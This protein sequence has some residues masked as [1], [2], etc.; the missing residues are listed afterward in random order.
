MSTGLQVTAPPQIFAPS[1]TAKIMWA[2]TGCLLPAAAWGVYL[3]GTRAALVLGISI[4]CAV[5]FEA[6]LAA[7]AGKSTLGDGSAVL[8]GVLLGMSM[9][10]AVPLFI[11]IVANFFAIGIVKW[12]FGGLGSNWMN[13]ALAGRVFVF[14]CWND[15]M[16]RWTA[17]SI[18]PGVADGTSAATP[19]GAVRDGLASGVAAEGPISM[20][21]RIGYPRTA[22]DASITEWLNER[23]FSA[24]NVEIPQGY[25]DLF[26][27][28]SAGS[29]GET[30]ALLLLL[31]S[32][33]LVANGISR[34][35]ITVSFFGGFALLTI[36][37]GGLRFGGDL[38]T[39]DVLFNLFSGGI[40]LVMF[41]MITDSVTAPMSSAGMMLYGAGAGA[42]ASVL[43]MYGAYPDGAALAVLVLNV[44]VPS[45]D[46]LSRRR[47]S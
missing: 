15:A 10:P 34:W 11:P 21:D 7:L 23:V 39:G 13:P 41:Y 40:A 5:V 37:F 18:L 44:F 45:I 43:R 33:Y 14:F 35:E 12:S 46:R 1:S 28:Q 8:T 19:L 30:S 20:L 27:G 42:L 22:L 36:L 6:A 38:L 16:Q 29:I 47:R 25:V 3:F 2:V 31:G 26:F 4:A 24:V 17:P 9:P 32:I